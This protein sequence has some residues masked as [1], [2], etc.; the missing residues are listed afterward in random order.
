MTHDQIIADLK[1]RGERNIQFRESGMIVSFHGA[2]T[3]NYWI[4]ENRQLVCV[5]CYTVC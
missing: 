5:N 1:S 3:V 4:V 2:C